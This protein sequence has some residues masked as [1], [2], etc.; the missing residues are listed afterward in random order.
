MSS[1]S[2]SS[3]EQLR[4]VLASI[5]PAPGSPAAE[6]FSQVFNDL[7]QFS[8]WSVETLGPEGAKDKLKDCIVLC[9]DAATQAIAFR[10]AALTVPGVERLVTADVEASLYAVESLAKSLAATVRAVLASPVIT[11][12]LL[13]FH[14]NS[15]DGA[16]A[17]LQMEA[18]I[19]CALL[20]GAGPK[21]EAVRHAA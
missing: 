18:R 19:L 12:E 5:L 21:A 3:R 4:T 7:Q 8:L 6:R 20:I 2:L 9:N 10:L 13:L 11:P 14:C 17:N 1:T 16:L 15:L